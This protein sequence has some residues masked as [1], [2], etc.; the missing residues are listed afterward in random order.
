MG[1]KIE[2]ADNDFGVT[3]MGEWPHPGVRITEGQITYKSS[4]HIMRAVHVSCTTYLCG[5]SCT[6][7]LQ[8][9]R[10]HGMAGRP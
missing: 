6:G 1:W 3:M 7:C 10:G 2:L 5:A 4:E 8:I 9:A